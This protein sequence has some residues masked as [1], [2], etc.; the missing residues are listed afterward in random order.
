MT[1]CFVVKCRVRALHRHFCLDLRP[2]APTASA[3]IAKSVTRR[4]RRRMTSSPD[5]VAH[6]IGCFTVLYGSTYRTYPGRSLAPVPW[7]TFL[8]FPTGFS[9][10]FP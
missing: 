10:D 4:H 8:P 9:Q 3:S 2:P 6:T 5:C 1:L 7:S